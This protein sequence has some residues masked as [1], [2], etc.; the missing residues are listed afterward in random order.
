MAGVQVH[1]SGQKSRGNSF[2]LS[3]SKAYGKRAFLNLSAG[4]IVRL[5]GALVILS[6]LA[7]MLVILIEALPLFYAPEIKLER[8]VKTDISPLAV[9]IDEY[10]EVATL[11][12]REG[13]FFSV[14]LKSQDTEKITDLPVAAGEKTFKTA[15]TKDNTV[16][17]L[18]SA[19]KVFQRKL[20]YP[21]EY[22]TD[23]T[24]RIRAE[25]SGE[26]S[27]N[28]NLP[29]TSEV[30]DFSAAKSPSGYLTA[31]LL[32]DGRIVLTERRIKKALMGPAK[33]E[34]HSKEFKGP[35]GAEKI[36]LDSN[37][38]KLAIA[39]G[40]EL[41]LYRLSRS[42]GLPELLAKNSSDLQSKIT[43]L[44]FVLGDQTLVAGL[45]DGRVLTFMLIPTEPKTLK[46]IYEF[47]KH[48]ARVIGVQASRRNKAFLTVDSNGEA[49]VHYATTGKTRLKLAASGAGTLYTFAPKGNG[50]VSVQADGTLK[51]YLVNDPHPEISLNTLFGRV[52]YEGYSEPAMVWQ[53]TG[54]IDEF[55]SKFSLTPLIFGT[56]KGAFYALL[57]AV[58]LALLAA[59]YTSQFM[60]PALKGI[61]KPSVELMAALPSVVIGFIAGLWFAPY[62]EDKLLGVFLLPP[63]LVMVVLVVS[64]IY[65]FLR[66][67][68]RFQS[69]T[70]IELFIVI[71]AV[72]LSCYL[73]FLFADLLEHV[74]MAGDF[75][76]WLYTRFNIHVD[77]RNSVVAG[78]AVGFAV[79]PIIFTISEDC[80]SSV[81][82]HLTAGAL[83]LGATRW[84]TAL[85]VVLPVAVPGIFSAVMIGVGRAVG[86][87]MIV[88]MATGNTPIMD[89]S[90]FNGFR[91]LSANIAVELPEAPQGGTLYRVLFLS[92]LV[93]FV[94]TFILNTASE[95]VRSRLKRKYKEL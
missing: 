84:Q 85:K 1:T 33:V 64:F 75:S 82:R 32:G 77:Q 6:V 93:L 66:D 57:F 44:G 89:W 94:M 87:T 53:S 65:I 34:V 18:T 59:F 15:K 72:I 42:S 12:D 36:L 39:A 31:T 3:A 24:R 9:S 56:L 49:A 46:K 51:S 20:L 29:P 16:F 92:A 69:T 7:I 13:N 60:S 25:I 26:T 79:L 43:S 90:I 91:A 74:F 17:V 62:I 40:K 73:A 47:K 67:R 41:A 71:P 54:G 8:S 23:N 86:E 5:G 78:V 70:G 81:P 30:L 63:T 48:S 10:R 61:I 45:K 35:V 80:L 27:F 38:K 76:Q 21:V 83:A 19:G 28:I 22:D 14:N 37:G 52:W 68:I 88:L 55:E 50:V 2:A 4:I 95:F 11:L 58:P